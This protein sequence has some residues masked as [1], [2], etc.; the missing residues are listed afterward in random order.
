MLRLLKVFDSFL[1]IIWESKTYS[2]ALQVFWPTLIIKK[3]I[4]AL[5]QKFLYKYKCV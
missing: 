5:Q 2:K 3:S 1:A 4:N